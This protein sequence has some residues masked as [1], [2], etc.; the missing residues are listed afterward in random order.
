MSEQDAYIQEWEAIINSDDLRKSLSTHF[1]YL[2]ER[3]PDLRLLSQIIAK[4]ERATIQDDS[5][6]VYLKDADKA[7]KARA[8]MNNIPEHFPESYK[9]CLRMHQTIT[10]NG[11]TFG[12]NNASNIDGYK[13]ELEQLGEIA[14]E[15]VRSKNLVC[16]FNTDG[17]YYF[18]YHPSKKRKDGTPKLYF[19]IPHDSPEISPMKNEEE[20]VRTSFLHTL[21]H[22]L[23]LDVT[24]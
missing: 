15:F 24:E 23:G 1:S 17:T 21:A 22:Q 9:V 3:E 13:E 16:P 2:A 14:I 18:I 8:P 7:L 6:Q 20:D 19:V 10:F 5:L 12:E 4:A 11:S